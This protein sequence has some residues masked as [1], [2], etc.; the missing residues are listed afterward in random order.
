MGNWLWSTV[1]RKIMKTHQVCCNCL[2]S[3]WKALAGAANAAV[4][5]YYT[6]G[7]GVARPSPEC[8][9]GR[10]VLHGDGKTTVAECGACTVG[11]FTDN[12]NVRELQRQ[13]RGG[14]SGTTDK[15]K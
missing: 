7:F 8:F 1:S 3:F 10:R 4:P 15:V 6:A 5:C 9:A 14:K 13:K 2:I 12:R 11:H